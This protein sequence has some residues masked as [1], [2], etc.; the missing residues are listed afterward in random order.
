M[1]NN[2][3]EFDATLGAQPEKRLDVK[4]FQAADPSQR[5]MRTRRDE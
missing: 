3:V 4:I 5:V 2:Q 1:V